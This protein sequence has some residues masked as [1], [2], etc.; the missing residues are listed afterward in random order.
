MRSK[1]AQMV[2]LDLILALAFPLGVT[3]VMALIFLLRVG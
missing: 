1:G 3:M 2:V